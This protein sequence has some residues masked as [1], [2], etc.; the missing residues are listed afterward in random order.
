[1]NLFVWLL[2]ETLLRKMI[3]GKT[4]TRYFSFE[5]V[6]YFRMSAFVQ[7]HWWCLT[8]VRV[9]IYASEKSN[10]IKDVGCSQRL[11]CFIFLWLRNIILAILIDK[12]RFRTH[13]KLND[14]SH[15]VRS[16]K[17]FKYRWKHYVLTRS[18]LRKKAKLWH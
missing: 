13:L 15:S 8:F 3:C 12:S 7:K 5:F 14:S 10:Q 16:S 1:M 18:T 11:K 2:T 4:C 9:N 6:Y 17:T